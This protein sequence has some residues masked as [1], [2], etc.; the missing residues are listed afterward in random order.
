MGTST[1]GRPDFPWLQLS[2]YSVAADCVKT[3]E[4]SALRKEEHK[5]HENDNELN[6]RNNTRGF[7][8]SC[9]NHNTNRSQQAN[10]IDDCLICQI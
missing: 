1:W 8:L 6:P 2:G 10:T 4:R 9:L 7:I 3:R 5:S